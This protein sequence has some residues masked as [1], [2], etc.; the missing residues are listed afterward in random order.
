MSRLYRV[1]PASQ[2][3]PAA[4]QHPDHGEYVVPNPAHT[5][6]SDDALVRAYPWL[7]VADSEDESPVEQATRAPGEKRAYRRAK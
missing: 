1:R 2:G 4:V 3:G 5:F 6:S 7:F